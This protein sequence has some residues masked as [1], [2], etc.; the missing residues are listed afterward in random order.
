MLVSPDELKLP[1]YV[2]KDVLKEKK[3][4]ICTDGLIWSAVLP[5]LDVLY[6][7]RVQKERFFNEEDYL[8]L[9]RQLRAHARDSLTP[10]PEQTCPFCIRCP[11]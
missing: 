1:S 10:R 7:T 4:G 8:R 5:E 6:M 11:A 9:K 3:H 2:T